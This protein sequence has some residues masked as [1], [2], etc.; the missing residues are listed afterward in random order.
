MEQETSKEK[1]TRA[2]QLIKEGKKNEG[3]QI[4]VDL[5]KANPNDENLWLWLAVC[6]NNKEKKKEFLQRALNINPENQIAKE[7]LEKII[8]SEMQPDLSQ[9]L[10]QENV[11]EGV[12][13]DS[14]KKTKRLP[15][16]VVGSGVTLIVI[17]LIIIFGKNIPNKII[18][19][20]VPTRCNQQLLTKVKET[21][22]I[23]DNGEVYS[24]LGEFS[25][26]FQQL[27]H[28]D[29]LK[30]LEWIIEER[31]KEGCVVTLFGGK[32][33]I[34]YN[35]FQF[36]VDLSENKVSAD[37]Q[38]TQDLFEFFWNINRDYLGGIYLDGKE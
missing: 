31:S 36:Y 16:I 22:I 14:K 18:E 21:P 12:Q 15:I 29:N 24:Y 8:R 1:L 3:G 25:E 19:V 2:I 17:A 34:T 20:V 11:D 26:T 9:I 32:N 35:L 37:N 13:S 30:N 5:T 38:D 7:G 4:L 33:A 27:V 23:D 28:L 6:V 10:S